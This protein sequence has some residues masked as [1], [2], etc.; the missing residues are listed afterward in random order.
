MVVAPIL[1]LGVGIHQTT[2]SREQYA[3]D[4]AASRGLSGRNDVD[5]AL[6]ILRLEEADH[7]ALVQRPL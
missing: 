1:P 3:Q 7:I 5:M 6:R 2:G 4:L